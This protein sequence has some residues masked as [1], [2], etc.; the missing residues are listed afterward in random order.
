MLDD[1]A[2]AGSQVSIVVSTGLPQVV[3]PQL[4]G[5][6]AD[7]A[8]Q[9]LRNAG[10]DPVPVFEAVPVGSPQAGRVISQSPAAFEEVDVNPVVTIPVGE[11]TELAT[12]TTTA[13]P[14]TT[15]TAAP[16]TT[17]TAAP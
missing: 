14:T 9:T 2:A 13:A 8:I 17:T 3:V 15:T 7:T 11:A 6:F 16:T 1:C 4:D 12:T 5:L 10:L